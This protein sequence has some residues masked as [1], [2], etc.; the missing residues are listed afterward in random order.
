M[1]DRLPHMTPDQVKRALCLLRQTEPR[2]MHREI[3]DDIGV[4]TQTISQLAVRHGIRRNGISE[5]KPLTEWQR[6]R[7]RYIA[8]RRRDGHT[9][10]EIG[11]SLGIGTEAA[12]IFWMHHNGKVGA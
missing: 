5:P 4:K 10:A 3:A 8:R 6:D 1:T 12:R 7:T 11:A 2:L 9:W